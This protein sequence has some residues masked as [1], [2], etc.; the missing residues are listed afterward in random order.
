MGKLVTIFENIFLEI[1]VQFAYNGSY[2]EFTS[3]E[4]TL[5]AYELKIWRKN[6]GKNVEENMFEVKTLKLGLKQVILK[7]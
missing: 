5:V 3:V 4:I 1:K 2:I 6:M 7:E